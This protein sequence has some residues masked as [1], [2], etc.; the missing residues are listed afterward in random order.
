MEQVTS[1]WKQITHTWNVNIQPT[2]SPLWNSY[3]KWIKILFWADWN[4]GIFVWI[5]IL[6]YFFLFLILIP[7]HRK[8]CKTFNQYQQQLVKSVDEIIYLIAK[9]QK[10]ANISKKALWWDPHFAMMKEI[11][12]NGNFQ[13]LGN[14]D[15]I[16]ETTK[17]VEM[18]FQRQITSDEQRKTILKLEKK[19]KR[20]ERQ[21]N[22]IWRICTCFTLG[23]YK[24][25][26]KE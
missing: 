22:I 15:V 10:D 8:I 13:Y 24:L 3:L 12:K 18:I 26:W 9:F 6:C 16:K 25:F 1:F 20:K 11:F 2:I 14:I 4:M 19:M 23:I 17:K 7:I 21:K 5:L